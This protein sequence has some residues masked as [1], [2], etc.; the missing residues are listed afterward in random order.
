MNWLAHIYLSEPDTEYRLGNLL[1]DILRPADRNGYGASFDRG[2]ECHF[3]IDRFTDSHKAVKQSRDLLYPS[4]GH[5]SRV[6]V[7]I[8]Y[9]HFLA[10]DWDSYSDM[11]Y[12]TYVQEFHEAA[13]STRLAFPPYATERLNQIIAENWLGT[14]DQIGEV[15]RALHR[16]ALRTRKP[17]GTDIAGA[18]N[19]LRLHCE[20]LQRGFA[21]FFADLRQ[22]VH[23]WRGT[24]QA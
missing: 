14:Y 13:R 9:D 22:A 3:L 7:D 8:F 23:K 4:Y 16:L 15:D 24:S 17:A 20:E 21:V 19:E 1:T 10:V 5:Y 12:H 6:L 11:P 18:A 2:V